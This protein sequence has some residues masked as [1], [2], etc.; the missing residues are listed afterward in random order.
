MSF[1]GE[2]QMIFVL[3]VLISLVLFLFL[4]AAVA[5]YGRE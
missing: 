4:W 1:E 2:A 5:N 3:I